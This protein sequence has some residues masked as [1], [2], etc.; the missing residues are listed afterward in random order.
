MKSKLI[1]AASVLAHVEV[2]PE[3]VVV[4]VRQDF[5]TGVPN[6][7]DIPTTQV[8][9][10]IPAGLES[11]TPYVKPGWEIETKKTGEG[12]DA[13]VTEIIWSGGEIGVGLRDSFVFRAMIPSEA[14]TLVWKAYQTYSDGTVVSWDQEERVGMVI[15]KRIKLKARLQKQPLLTT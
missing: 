14:T 7:K 3:E 11:V 4:A 8:R 5:T 6:E 2:M 10:V 15:L 12:E 9:L 1:A 13:L